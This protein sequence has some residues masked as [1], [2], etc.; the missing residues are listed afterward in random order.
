LALPPYRDILKRFWVYDPFTHYL[1]SSIKNILAFFGEILNLKARWMAGVLNQKPNYF[2]CHS[3]LDPESIVFEL[4]SRFRGNDGL[5]NNVE[6]YLAQYT[7]H[8]LLGEKVLGL[9]KAWRGISIIRR[10]SGRNKHHLFTAAECQ[11]TFG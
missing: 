3:G 8:F 9:L 1:F 2:V 10:H 4:D 6:K 5:E 7:N 11:D